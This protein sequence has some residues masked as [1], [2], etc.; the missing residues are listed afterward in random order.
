MAIG[1]LSSL[2]LGSKVLNYDVIDK[3]KDAD[4]K[5]LIAPLDKK[6]EQNVEKQKALVEI[7]TLLSALKGPVKT[8][9]DY[10]TYISRKSN[11][12]GDALS[13]SVGAGVPI[14][15]IKVDVQNLA[16]GDI[17]E[18]G[19]KFSSRDDIFS[20]VDTT[21]KF[22]TQN[23]DYAVDIKAGMTLGDVA[24]SITDA[25]NGE[26]MGIVMKTGG[27]DPYQLMVNTKN[28]G[29]DNR[30]YFGSHLQST[31]TN[32]NALSL[33]VDGSG[34]SEVSLNLKGADGNMHEVPIMLELPESASIKQKNTAIQ[35]AMEQAL[36]ND[37]NFKDLIANGDISI[38]TLHG[39]E[40]LIIND[41]RG[42]NIE[43]KGSKAKELGFSQTTTQESDLLKSSRTIKEGKLEGVISLNGQKLDLKA[44][45]KEG[46]T[47]EENT[48]AIIQAI[49][50]KEGLNAFKNAEGKLVINSKTGILT[51]KG[52]DALGKDSLKDLG[53]NAGM[54]QS[55]EASQNTLFMSKN[56]QKA[57]DSQFT[58]NG[59]SITRP[60]NEVN[61]VIS[62]VNITL[63][64]TTEPNKPAIISVSRDN[65]A[66]ID[67]LKEFV[68]AY[69]E[70]IPKL[71]EDT[72]Y[73]ADTKIAGI[74]N[75][76][77]D[78]R[79]IRSSLNNVFSYSVHTDNGVESL[80]KYGLSLDDKGVMSLDEAKL[81]S[82]LNSNP[83]ATQDFFYGSDSKDMGG[84]EIHQEGIFSKF[85]QVIANLIDGGN[86]KLKIYE[87][88]LDRDAKSLTKDKEN[89]QELL[90]TRYNIMAE[91]FAAYDSQISKAN[92][93]FN[94]VQM[95]IDQAAAKK[96]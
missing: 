13:A 7:K 25:T 69:N 10:S 1:S 84:R 91:R 78:I 31:L 42:G 80:M 62:G 93:K 27:N 28:T 21:L 52:E 8:L 94:S 9:S 81:S 36:E 30:I 4:E 3:L 43:I 26:V 38:D 95:M 53:L 2:G 70:L 58:Y 22:Y 35:K 57:S 60:T 76:V 40:S 46:N 77:G 55:Y 41:R 86:A 14:Q 88:S 20:Q 64:Q 83:K 90:K 47:S 12:T 51:I 48:D 23:K 5:A 74:F 34:K 82:A 65:Q 87:D 29:E 61:D 72:R 66:I 33:G 63:E 67:S 11:V 68:K 73:D 18:L 85:N 54:V 89:A 79:T 45:T 16:Q 15:D 6:M 59:V 32:K 17:N 96:N 92:Q 49:N 56:L 37:P 75:G 19:A 24:Q 71:D 44:L 50:A 39:G